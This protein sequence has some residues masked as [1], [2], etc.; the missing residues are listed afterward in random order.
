MAAMS[1]TSCHT[2]CLTNLAGAGARPCA[3]RLAT[4]PEPFSRS[5]PSNRACSYCSHFQGHGP[6]SG[7][8][9]RFLSRGSVCVDSCRR[10]KH[11]TAESQCKMGPRGDLRK[12]SYPLKST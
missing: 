7:R 1:S 11:D 8:V 9:S 10:T 5:T 2:Y 3:G 6:V 4:A 12:E